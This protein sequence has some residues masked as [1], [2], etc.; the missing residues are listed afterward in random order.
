MVKG[1]NTVSMTG[2]ASIDESHRCSTS[3][4]ASVRKGG[5][6]ATASDVILR[7]VPLHLFELHA[8]MTDPSN[9]THFQF[10]ITDSRA[11]P[12][13]FTSSRG[14]SAFHVGCA[15]NTMTT[16][17]RRSPHNSLLISLMCFDV[18]FVAAWHRYASLPLLSGHTSYRVIEADTKS[19]HSR[20]RVC[21]SKTPFPVLKRRIPKASN[22]LP[23]PY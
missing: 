19:S 21:V 3:E 15:H 1:L 12:I 5:A 10:F 18:S 23:D 14:C 16:K 6:P 20:S 11:I 22:G 13:Y 4:V 17:R 8:C 9:Y 2:L 7:Q